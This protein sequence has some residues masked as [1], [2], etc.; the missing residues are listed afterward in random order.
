MKYFLCALLILFCLTPAV[1]ARDELSGIVDIRS[2]ERNVPDEA[3]Q[4]VRGLSPDGAGS[5]EEGIGNLWGQVGALFGGALSDSLK[6]A[7]MLL[8]IALLTG[9]AGGVTD[10]RAAGYVTLAGVMGVAVL[11]VTGLGSFIASAKD[12]LG[13]LA[14]YS[15]LLLPSLA[16]AG[17]AAGQ[18]ASSVARQAVTALFWDGLITLYDRLLFPLMYVYA[19]LLTLQSAFA[20]DGVKRLAGLIKWL[21]GGV[22][23]LSLTVFTLYLTISGAISGQADAL[24]MKS[25]RVTLS[26]MVPVVGGIIG[27]AS[28]TLV[29][30]AGILKNSIGLF[31]LF[32]VLG[33]TAGPCVGLGVRYIAFKLTAALSGSV[34]DERLAGYMDGLSSLFAMVLGMTAASGFLLCV[35]II[36]CVQAGGGM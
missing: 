31:G 34:C 12:S 11:S 2:L 33:V 27:D 17:A 30:G 8:A 14:D 24:A 36:S 7:G 21:V 1:S 29:A 28:E 32:V 13:R 9:M 3:E 10:G 22:L 23:G 26:G 5:L 35:S 18:P 25:A 15:K 19:A 6:T 16:A 20:Q 4:T